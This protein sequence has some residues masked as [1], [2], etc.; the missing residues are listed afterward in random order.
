MAQAAFDALGV[1]DLSAGWSLTTLAD[2]L[3]GKHLLLVLDNCEHL[4]DS[5]AVFATTLL[6]ACPK[7]RLLAT[8]RQ[9]LG[10]AGEVRVPVPPMSLPEEGDDAAV[11]RLMNSE[12]IWLLSE[13]A[14]AVVPEFAINAKNA[15]AVLRLC[16][17]LDGIPLAL[18]L[19]A[20]RLGAL[21]LDQ[22][23]QDLA[24]ELAIL[25][26]GNRGAEARHQTLEATI[27]WSYGLL[28]EPERL[29]W[30]RLSVFAG[31]FDHEAAIAVCSDAQVPAERIVELL[32]ALVEKSILKRQLSGG[33]TA[34]YT[35]LETLR[36]Y[37]RVRLREIHEESTTQKRHFDW[38]CDLGRSVGG[39]DSRQAQM[40][41]RI[42]LER[43]NL[44]A[45]LDFSLKRS[46]EAAAV[47]ELTVH[48]VPYWS[49]RGPFSD[50]RRVLTSLA[51]LAPDD[52]RPR[53]QLL[54]VAAAV[55]SFQNDLDAFAALSREGLRIAGLLNDSELVAYA[56]ILM[57]THLVIEGSN[58][59]AVEQAQAAVA[60][61]R[62]IH[63]RPLEMVTA[64][65]ACQVFLW[66]GQ[67]DRAIEFGEQGLTI[68]KER[69]ELWTRGY[70]LN[71]LSQARWRQGER[72]L[73]EAWAREG[74]AIKRALDD[75]NGLQLLLET[76]ACMVAEGGAHHRA[77]TLLGYAE[78]VRQSSGL[79]RI[80]VDA[81]QREHERSL[82]IIVPALGLKSYEAAH[83][84]GLAMTVDEGMAFVLEEKTPTKQPP[85]SSSG[86]TGRLTRREQEIA[87]LVSQ[88]LS[89]KQIAA[90]LVVS[91]RTAETH[92]LNILNK[93]GFNSR[94]Q[95]ASWATAQQPT[96]TLNG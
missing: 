46:G 80:Y 90:R 89:N 53:A 39:Y 29:L 28:E 60:L 66:C 45:A 35:L 34:R 96:P 54:L 69:G 91:E 63:D 81:A 36:Q 48:L 16:R 9:P 83:R 19:A 38:I 72:H 12:A 82:A 43:D 78:R 26:K 10:M 20:V 33:S 18:E 58:A 1:S 88:G 23:S 59:E 4:L 92:I 62:S 84:R 31:G 86:S 30:A 6:T 77:A 95:I 73:A 65:G 44:W 93:L 50:V 79:A 24:G 13:R 76:Y 75:R 70:F 3:A 11:E 32:G 51:E 7:V 22:L 71:V 94:T 21:T 41:K 56:L 25:G 74:V 85:A 61:A 87:I 55:A 14:A 2:Y 42:H 68:S 67:L 17:A 37:A 5:C 57:A 8:S 49:G 15:G 40:F 47:A 52:S 27:G 64:A